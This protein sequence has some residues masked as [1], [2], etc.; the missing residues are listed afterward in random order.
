MLLT[1]DFVLFLKANVLLFLQPEL[2][3]QKVNRVRQRVLLLQLTIATVY[4]RVNTFT[5]LLSSGAVK[6]SMEYSPVNDLPS[7]VI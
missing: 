1:P 7:I 3:P 2:S 4:F 5:A 6:V